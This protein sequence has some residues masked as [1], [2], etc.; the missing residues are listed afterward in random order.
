MRAYFA[1][2]KKEFMEYTR[3]YKLVIMGVVFLLFGIMNP[4]IAKVMPDIIKS[5]TPAGMEIKIPPPTALDAW[6]QFFKNVGQ[7]G[8]LVLIIVFSGIMANEF[9]RGTLINILTKG[10]KRSTVIL[11]K[12]TVAAIIWTSS[13]LLSF[14]VSYFYTAYFWKMEGMHHVFL[15]FFSLWLFGLL[16]I[17][18]LIF[19]GVLFKNI[20]GSLFLSG[21]AIVVTMLL[22]INPKFQKYNPITLASENMLLLTSKKD[23]SDFIPAVT[24]CGVFI[25]VLVG[26]SVLLFNKKQL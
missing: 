11:S 5:A 15:T 18:L 25:I 13:Y 14:L 21:G 17:T 16:L 10:M 8:L 24:V 2:I 9:S 4:A 1:F 23:L 22:N 12:I 6:A 19:G 26:G 7:M 3:T 20:F